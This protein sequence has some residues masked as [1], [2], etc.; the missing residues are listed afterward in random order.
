M[1]LVLV[2]RFGF[3]ATG[4]SAAIQA[5][6]YVAP[7]GC[8]DNLGTKAKP[9]ATIDKA[10]QAVLA[11][12]KDMTGD[13]IVVLR[14]GVY[15]IDRPIVFDATD[16]GANGHDVIYR[17]APREVP[18]VCGGV[19]IS[20]WQKTRGPLW[21]AVVPAVRDG[22]TY[23]RSL[24]V[25][26]K[27][28][29]PARTPNNDWRFAAGPVEPIDRKNPNPTVLQPRGQPTEATKY[30]LRYQDEDIKPWPNLDD[31]IAVVYHAWTASRHH[32]ASVDT[33]NRI[34]RFHNPSN[35]PM[36]WWGKELRYYVENVR[37]ALDAPGE[38]YLDRKTGVLNYYPRPDED[39]TKVQVLAPRLEV[40]LKLEGDSGA[41]KPVQHLRF[42][43]ITFQCTDWVMP[44][45]E[46]VD[47][48]AAA[49]LKTAT[50][51]ARGA[52]HCVF[53]RCNIA[54]TGGY[55]LW[56]EGGC[57]D[58]RLVQCHLHDLGAGGI[59]IGE[60]DL[61]G[62][63]E[64]QTERNEVFNCF[65]HD[66]G[67]VYPAGVG[68]WIGMSS[69]NEVLHNEISDLLYTGISVGWSWGYA[70]SSAHHNAIE[71][72]HIH[73]LGWGKLSD[74]GGIY[75]LGVSPGTTVRNNLI[76][77]VLA[78]SYGGWGLY[79]D[80][81]SSDMLWE[82]N[83]VYRVKD[84]CFI[85]NFGRENVVR[86]NI[87]AFSSLGGQLVRGRDNEPHRSFSFE[88]NIV[89]YAQG[90]L[91]AGNW[92]NG[93]YA[94]DCNCYWNAAGKTPVFPG[95]LTFKQ[96]QAKGQDV[97]SMIADPEF[98]APDRYDFRLKDDSPALKLGFQP[99][100]T[101]TIGLVGPAK[102]IALPK[103]VRRPKLRLPGD[104]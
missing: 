97:H 73:H 26:G 25:D 58:N 72:N 81:G 36:G 2:L 67:R 104:D 52:R 38:F 85:Q 33:A 91:F 60:V 102:W 77:D 43:G 37:E 29:T 93:Q 62:N 65:I 64:Q 63:P 98:I 45:V 44:R 50:V 48:Q 79:T 84:G 21:K 39:M 100:D 88:R 71:Y 82:N 19:P 68:V 47:G 94:M 40:L 7:G 103:Q 15:A 70:P 22:Q 34:V 14:G 16:S 78:F 3:P 76:H 90:N 56:L 75:S 53:E 86:N 41:G 95:N 96:W 30:G 13:I 101:S 51:L 5:T 42:E 1:V 28:C 89:Y 87:L 49:G 35:W 6:F 9:F 17:A 20:G 23:F 46:M 92:S 12:K 32:I 4:Y 57:K 27:R 99:I 74:M 18:V 24:F 8:D 59:R 66:G 61:P 11:V 55:G 80:E 31:A 10:R 83:I 54:H 69:H